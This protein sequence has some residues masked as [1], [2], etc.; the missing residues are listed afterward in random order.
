MAAESKQAKWPDAFLD[1]MRLAGDPLADDAVA[2]LFEAGGIFSVWELMK[3]LIQNDHPVPDQLPVQLKSYLESASEISPV[4]HAVVEHGQRLFERC[5]PEILVVLACYSLPASYAARKGVQVLYRTGYLNN[6]PNHRLF[7]TAQMIMDVLAPGG[8]EPTGR[9]IRTAQKVRLMHAA[10]RRL[11]LTDPERPWDKELGVP[12]NQ[13][14]LAGT[15]M[16]FTFLIIDGLHRL[17]IDTSDQEQQGYL[18]TWRIIARIIGVQEA[19]IPDNMAEAK[20]LC[21][22][23]QRRQVQPCPEGKAMND[24]LLKMMEHKLLPG[25][26][27]RWPA[28][29]MRHFLPAEIADG[30]AIPRH[31]FEE[32]ALQ[33]AVAF[34]G[35]REQTKL[36]TNRHLQVLRKCSLLLLRGMVSAELGGK[37]TPFILPTNL[38]HGW[39]QSHRMKLWPRPR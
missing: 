10:I 15:L 21:D 37:R 8:L 27:R 3:K 39:A 30:F 4:R 1:E 35:E 13:E 36:E 34:M 20:Q 2:A 12:I 11:L 5:G 9:G 19:L 17:G 16:V 28:S 25:R 23:I 18:E 6:R 26:F 38:H 31:E 29:L 14:D 22:V 32:H 7:E 33:S 24:A